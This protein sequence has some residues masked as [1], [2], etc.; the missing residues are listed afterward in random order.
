MEKLQKTRL[1]WIKLYQEV[2]D[3]GIVCHN[4]LYSSTKMG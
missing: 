1:G 2:K 3:A 4:T